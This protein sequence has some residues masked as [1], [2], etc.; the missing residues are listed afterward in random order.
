MG[1]VRH[2]LKEG[3]ALNNVE[4]IRVMFSKTG[5]A[6]Y[7]SHLD[8]MRTMTRVFRRAHIPL[9][10]TEGFSKHPYIT[11]A[12]PLSLGYEGACESLDFRLEQ[13]MQMSDIVDALNANMPEGI[14]VLSAAP[15]VM[16][17][18]M[19]TASR[20]CITVP[21]TDRERVEEVLNRDVIE[22]QKLT[23][24]KVL[25]TLDIKPFIS[26]VSFLQEENDL[27]FCLTL[28]TGENAVNPSLLM[29]AIYDSDDC[30]AA[31]VRLAVYGPDG[32]T[33]E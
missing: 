21:L 5:R 22:V 18:G 33:F 25:K 23:K 12:A 20:W 19:I 9:W 8:L 3:F 16:K 6:K 29:K 2:A 1:V 15:A 17:A 24:K 31:V 26:D 11:F 14:R 27:K 28:P 7:I 32:K 4:T 30:E 10:Y 13:P